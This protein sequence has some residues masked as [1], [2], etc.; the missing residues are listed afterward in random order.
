MRSEAYKALEHALFIKESAQINHG[1]Q[2]PTTQRSDSNGTLHRLPKQ[3]WILGA[4]F[5]SSLV[6][7]ERKGSSPTRRMA[8]L[9]RRI[10]PRSE[11]LAAIAAEY[12]CTPEANPD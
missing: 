10:A 12:R 3:C 5:T 1:G 9:M 11:S 4:V 8:K 2:V 6:I 7:L